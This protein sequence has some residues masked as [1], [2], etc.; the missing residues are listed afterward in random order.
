MSCPIITVVIPSCNRVDSLNVCLQAFERQTLQKALFEVI[1]VNDGS[2]DSTKQF[3]DSFSKETPLQIHSIHQENQG[4][5]AARNRGI[6]VARGRY[7]AFTDDD[8][9]VPCDWL[10]QIVAQLSVADVA[11]AGVG[12]PLDSVVANIDSFTSRFIQYLDEFNHIPVLCRFLI[13]PR[14]VSLLKAHDQVPYLRTS[15]AAFRRDCL[16]EIDGFDTDFRRP[17]G[18]DPDLCY[19][20]LAHN[21]QL[22]FL[23]DLVVA[24]QTRESISAYFRSLRN[25]VIGEVRTSSK[26]SAYNHPAIRMTYSFLPLQKILSIVISMARYPMDVISLIRFGK[27]QWYESPVFPA[28]VVA[29]KYYALFVTLQAILRQSLAKKN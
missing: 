27:C 11:I 20:L 12:G 16:L 13:R 7:I 25:Y 26:K 1:V 6:Q 9:I 19:R 18:E 29:S 15:N 17:G 23:K 21:H 24:H 5:S 10:E 4:V 2:Q 8:C 28:L 14:H 3:L 22:L